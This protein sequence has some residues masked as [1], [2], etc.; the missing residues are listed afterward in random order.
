MQAFGERNEAKKYKRLKEVINK[1][2]RKNCF[3]EKRGLVADDIAC[4]SY[5]QHAS[6]MGILSDA[7]TEK[8][9]LQLFENLI[10]DKSLIQATVYYQFYLFRAMKKVGL[11]NRYL[12]YLGAWR[13][14]L[15]NGL[16]T[17][18]EKPEPSRSDCHAWSASPNYD[19]LATVCGI[20]PASAGFK[21]IRIAPNLGYLSTV[22]GS[23]PHSKG[24]IAVDL[25]RE[26]NR[27]IGKVLLPKGTSGIFIFEKE[28]IRL[29]EGENYVKKT[30]KTINENEIKKRH[31]N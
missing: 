26:N 2:V 10:A 20:E 27:L 7:F 12:D 30:F 18:A 29:R 13:G 8:E 31:L 28:K 6:I 23:V 1:S 3:N 24:L 16:T 15:A 9:Q 4:T 14:M 11:A 22:N 19:F 25:K 5:S 17:F 21:T